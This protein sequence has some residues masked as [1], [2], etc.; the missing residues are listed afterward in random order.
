MNER[1]NSEMQGFLVTV[2]Y[3]CTF[4]YVV[5]SVVLDVIW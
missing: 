1:L 2:T 4:S 5:G 3:I